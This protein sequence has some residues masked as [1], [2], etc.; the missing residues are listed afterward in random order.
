MHRFR[1]VTVCV[2]LSISVLL[3]MTACNDTL[4]TYKGVTII[5]SSITIR[6]QAELAHLDGVVQVL[7]SLELMSQSG[8]DPIRDLTPLSRLIYVGDTLTLFNMDGVSSLIPLGNLEV[9]GV[10]LTIRG[11]DDLRNLDGLQS[12]WGVGSRIEIIDN[13]SLE[14]IEG[15]SGLRQMANGS[16]R[17]YGNPALQS[18]VSFPVKRTVHN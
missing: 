10:E 5:P 7:G 3:A 14:S 6:T 18:L 13:G 8:M 2:F 11:L 1:S 12:L 15:L 4:T 9:V 16:I 17:I